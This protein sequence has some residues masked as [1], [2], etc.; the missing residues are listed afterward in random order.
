ML[1]DAVLQVRDRS[2]NR[3]AAAIGAVLARDARIEIHEGL[4]TLRALMLRCDAAVTA[5]GI[6]L[7]ELAVTATVTVAV[8]L[9]ANQ[10]SNLRASRLTGRY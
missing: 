3:S 7:I 6:R 2:G 10:E 4:V 5:G 9:V 8:W 1:P